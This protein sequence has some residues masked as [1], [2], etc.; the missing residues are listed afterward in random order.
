MEFVLKFVIGA[1]F[2]IGVIIACFFV[3]QIVAKLFL[4]V[5]LFFVGILGLFIILC[6]LGMV[7]N[8]A[9]TGHIFNKGMSFNQGIHE[10]L[11]SSKEP[12]KDSKHDLKAHEID[13]PHKIKGAKEVK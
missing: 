12:E 8:F 11:E 3:F 10:I 7:V 4:Y 13:A 6:G 2:V 1:I 9:T 5:V